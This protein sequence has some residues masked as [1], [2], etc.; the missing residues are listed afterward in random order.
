[1]MESHCAGLKP[2][3]FKTAKMQRDL[4]TV[5][6]QMGV[7]LRWTSLFTILF[8]V[9]LVFNTQN[10]L[11][12]THHFVMLHTKEMKEKRS[13]FDE[14]SSLRMAIYVFVAFL[15]FC[16]FQIPNCISTVQTET[17]C[18][19]LSGCFNLVLNASRVTASKCTLFSC[20]M[21]RLSDRI[22]LLTIFPLTASP[23]SHRQG[24]R[25]PFFFNFQWLIYVASQSQK[26]GAAQ[27]LCATGV[28]INLSLR[29]WNAQQ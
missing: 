15:F 5:K 25:L 19:W 10:M 8:Y 24:I 22:W 14:S 16:W 21:L 1:M 3:T 27:S 23:Q 17:K 12:S 18:P 11:V 9:R 20:H 7:Q 2:A 26:L 29:K 4:V 6:I 13:N 28:L